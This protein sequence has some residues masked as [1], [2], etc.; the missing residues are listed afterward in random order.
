MTWN[1][2]VAAEPRLALLLEEAQSYRGIGSDFRDWCANDIWYGRGP[3]EGHG[4][5]GRLS[6]LVGLNRRE[7]H[8]LLSTS[9]AY[10]L[11]VATVHGSLPPCREFCGCVKVV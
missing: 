8:H 3:G 10:E 6:L 11:S 1:D 4:I 5:K 7:E 9:A 2:L